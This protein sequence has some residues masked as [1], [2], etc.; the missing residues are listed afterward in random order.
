MKRALL[1][2]FAAISLLYLVRELEYEGV[3]RNAGGEFAKLRETFLEPQDYDMIYIGSSR[4]ECSF[5]PPI[6]DSVTGLRSYNIGMKGATMPFI[7]ASLEAYLVHSKAPKYVVLNIDIHSFTDSPDTVFDFPRYFPYLSNPALLK[8]LQEADPRFNTF[9]WC[10]PYSMPYFN[11]HYLDASLRGWTN[12]PGNYDAAYT[13]GWAPSLTNDSIGD[14][15]TITMK[16]VIPEPPDFIW[17]NLDRIVSLCRENNIELIIVIS[18]LFHRLEDNIADSGRRRDE[19][20]NYAASNHL[21]FMDF[22]GYLR[23]E[24]DL[25]SDPAHLNAAGAKVFSRQ[26]SARIGQYL[27]P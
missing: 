2:V 17:K 15:D 6:I 19:F 9:T 22:T 3:R 13:R 1:F 24:K 10:A 18:P 20:R 21:A 7:R 26:F 16:P 23:T 4:A 5:Y 27:H 14:L 12:N 8:G 11:A 25:F